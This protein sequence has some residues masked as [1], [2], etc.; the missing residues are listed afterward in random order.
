MRN[1]FAALALAASAAFAADLFR[2]DFSR[3]PPGL[4]SAP[5]GQLNGAI[6]E[7]HYLAHRGLP[8]GPW[9][10]AI[11]H[12]DAWVVSDEDG[13]PYTVRYEAVNAMLLN[14]F[15]KE[16][17]KVEALQ[18]RMAEQERVAVEQQ[19]VIQTLMADLR[20]QNTVIQNVSDHLAGNKSASGLV[21]DNH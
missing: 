3:Y 8:L 18:A 14:E 13:K 17:R 12:L 11:S 5:I 10:N 7:Y 20:K 15:L 1:A 6:Q 16:H 9:A 21:A 4:L 2:D 19:K